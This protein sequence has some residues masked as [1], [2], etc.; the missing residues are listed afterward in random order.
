M[1]SEI[2]T[3]H[4]CSN[5]LI[6]KYTHL[7]WLLEIVSYYNYVFIYLN[8]IINYNVGFKIFLTTESRVRPVI[9]QSV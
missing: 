9:A 1:P 2:P 7:K 5:S 6:G 8:R 3:E 4:D